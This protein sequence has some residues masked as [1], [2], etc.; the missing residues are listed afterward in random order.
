MGKKQKADFVVTG[1]DP[2]TINLSNMTLKFTE[3][4]LVVLNKGSNEA[5]VRKGQGKKATETQIWAAVKA[6]WARHDG[7]PDSHVIRV[8]QQMKKKLHFLCGCILGL[9]GDR[10]ELVVPAVWRRYF[11]L[12]T[13]NY[14]SNKRVSAMV[15]QKMVR[16]LFP[17]GGKEDDHAE[18]YLIAAHAGVSRGYKGKDQWNIY[19][20]INP[21]DR[22]QCKTN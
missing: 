22:T 1:V 9:A 2:G 7:F 8:E 5:I 6:W 17:E 4:E 21:K 3:D 14:T 13:G 19:K 18:A 12:S 11:G 10:G 15:C 16:E 20:L